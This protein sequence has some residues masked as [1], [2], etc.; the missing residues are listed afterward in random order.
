MTAHFSVILRR[1]GRRIFFVKR[2]WSTCAN[3]SPLYAKLERIFLTARGQNDLL[4]L[5]F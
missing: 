5:Y 3:S 1:F 2:V 4:L